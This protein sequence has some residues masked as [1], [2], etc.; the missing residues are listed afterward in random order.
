[1]DEIMKAIDEAFS[2]D[3]PEPDRTGYSIDWMPYG[4][5][6]T[7]PDGHQEYYSIGD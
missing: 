4:D 6:I 3:A 1:M 5:L 2:P 7:Y